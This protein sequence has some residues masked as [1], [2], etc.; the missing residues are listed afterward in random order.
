M[1]VPLYLVKLVGRLE[2]YGCIENSVGLLSGVHKLFDLVGH[3]LA[4]LWKS[5]ILWVAESFSY[6]NFMLF[7]EVGVHRSFCFCYLVNV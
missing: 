2:D 6:E 3:L 4:N 7:S 1:Q 5:I